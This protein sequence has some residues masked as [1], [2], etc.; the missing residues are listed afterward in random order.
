[1]FLSADDI[2]HLTG[3]KRK[4]RQVEWLR[5]EGIAFRVNACGF[6]V[7]HESAVAVRPEQSQNIPPTSW[8]PKPLR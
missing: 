7:V 8:T 4:S 6:P 1:M 3:R 5:A 2:Y